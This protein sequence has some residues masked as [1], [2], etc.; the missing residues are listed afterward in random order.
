[1]YLS[2]LRFDRHH[3]GALRRLSDPYEMH[4]FIWHAFPD[5]SPLNRKGA[6]DILWRVEPLDSNRADTSPTLIVQS[7]LEPDWN[8]PDVSVLACPPDVKEWEP[9]FRLN[10][11]LKFRLRANPTKRIHDSRTIHNDNPDRR[12][13]LAEK[14]MRVALLKEPEQIDWLITRAAERGFQVSENGECVTVA[15]GIDELRYDLRRAW[16]RVERWS[17]YGA[18]KRGQDNTGRMRWHGVDFEGELEVTDSDR[19]ADTIANGIGSAKAFGFGLLS[20][21]PVM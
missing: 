10:Q 6:R 3:P 17:G 15:N 1:M 2:R 11:R 20:V 21:A 5:E 14:G 9:V 8:R 19:F 13:H 12:K 7:Q 4:R 16:F 18:V